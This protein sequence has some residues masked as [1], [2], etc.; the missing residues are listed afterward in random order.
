ML[1]LR[2]TRPAPGLV[3]CTTPDPRPPGPDEVLLDVRATGVCGTDLHLD[4]WTASYHFAAASLPVT[5]GHE[6]SAAV[7]AAGSG[8]AGLAPGMLVAVRPSVVCGICAWCSSGDFDACT[9]RRGTG[10]T[11]DG[12]F[13]AQVVVPARN[14][15][16]LPEGLDADVAALAEPMTVSDESARMGEVQPGQRVLILGPGNIGLGIALFARA[17][18]AARVVVAGRHDPARLATAHAMGFEDTLDFGDDDMQARLAPFIAAGGFDVVFEATGVGAV[19]APALA[20][21]KPRGIL[22][23][24]GIH[25][26]P[27]RID[28]TALLRRH[29]Q[30]RGSYRA[31]ESAWPAVLDFMRTHQATLKRM[32]TRILPLEDAHEAFAL[33]RSRMATKVMIRPTA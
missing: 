14:C 8:V 9:T 11:R 4:E 6:F 12:A 16:P 30:I 28:L 2:K 22:V 25:A 7:R 23:V 13:A 24:T 15:V 29:Q 32:I 33:S 31:P 18:G 20:A 17:A 5:V 1:A 19:I 10:V 3:L 26:A 21:L 27:V